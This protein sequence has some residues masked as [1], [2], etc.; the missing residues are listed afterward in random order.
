MSKDDA[1]DVLRMLRDFDRSGTEFVK[2]VIDTWGG[3]RDMMMLL[4]SGV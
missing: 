3:D 2:K 4:F 1:C